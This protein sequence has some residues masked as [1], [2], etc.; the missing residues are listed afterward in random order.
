VTTDQESEIRRHM[1]Y[2][3]IG[4]P[5][6]VS[7]GPPYTNTMGQ[8]GGLLGF[9]FFE[10]YPL[11]QYRIR[12][13]ST[14]EDVQI[15]GAQSAFFS[16]YQGFA[17]AQISLT[18]GPPVAGDFVTAQING[19]A[20]TYTFIAADTLNLVA[21]GLAAAIN[22]QP[23]LS[24]VV[25]ALPQGPNVIIQARAFGPEA[26]ALTIRAF[27]SQSVTVSTVQV[28][29]STTTTALTGGKRVPGPLWL[30]PSSLVAQPIYGYLPIIQ[31]CESQITNSASGMDTVKAD[32]FHQRQTEL[33]AREGLYRLWCKKLAQFFGVP[34]RGAGA[35][36]GDGGGVRLA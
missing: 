8:A 26:N 17:Q 20:S 14:D 16:L 36:D 25:V 9:R 34:Y 10:F 13:I 3:L 2:P 18:G 1:G 33:A 15:L 19:V 27:S 28:G 23:T 11:L 35:Y 29:T 4:S 22:T 30:D 7:A 24:P 5:S 12:N 21:T 32:V 6:N 31:Y